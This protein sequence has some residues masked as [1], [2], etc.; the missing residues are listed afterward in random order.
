MK[1]FLVTGGAGFIGSH[2]VDML[3][4]RGDEAHVID[5]FLTGKR[6]RLNPKAIIH[7]SDIRNFEQI[8][9]L[10]VGMDG[11]FHTAAQPRMQYSIEQPQL[12][13]D[14]NVT[15][16]LN[17]LIAA[18]EAKVPR[19]VYS[20]SS[21]AYG[22]NNPIPFTEDMRPGPVIPY[23]IQKYVGE[24]YC[25][26]MPE[27]YGLETVCL[28]Y[29]NV[30]GP[31]QTTAKDG[32]YATVIGIFLE[33]RKQGQKMTVVP[34]GH[35]RRDFTHVSDIANGNLLAMESKKV[36]K[37]EVINLGTASNF[38]VLEIA[39]MIGG[40]WEF[41]PVRLGEARET[42]ADYSQAKELLSWEPKVTFEAGLEELK[43]INGIA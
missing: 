38:S 13:N 29:F 34:D 18:K 37:G 28:R 8:K 32:P 1:K 5:N 16:T 7:E 4:A 39:K 2:I 19:V 12:T 23:A 41:A 11:V 42:L 21:S 36:G 25:K 22:R 40:E 3:I 24:M 15:G 33:Q 35:Q 14:I 6:E 27:F 31:R 43:K 30:Y 10:F 9:P 17:V 26:M 20:A